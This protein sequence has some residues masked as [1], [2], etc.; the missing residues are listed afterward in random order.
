MA[1]FKISQILLSIVMVI[2][3]I[4]ISLKLAISKNEDCG[5]Y[6]KEA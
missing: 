2:L 1:S 5:K 6:Q 3:L 4:C